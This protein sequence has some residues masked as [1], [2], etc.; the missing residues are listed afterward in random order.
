[1]SGENHDQG[2]PLG[3]GG[4]FAGGFQGA[5]TVG[6]G[7]T[8]VFLQAE[9]VGEDWL[10]RITG[11]K[12]H[13]GAVATAYGALVQQS[14]V[15]SHKEGPLAEVCAAQWA[16]LTGR[17]AVAVVGIHQDEATKLE[18]D[19]IVDHVRQ[20]LDIL[21]TRWKEASGVG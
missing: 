14:V 13:V 16:L 20:G 8:E 3:G 19:G 10:L 1:M 4:T 17:V 7:R 15:G 2:G 21:A 18:I 9:P 6:S 11:G 12:A 5:V